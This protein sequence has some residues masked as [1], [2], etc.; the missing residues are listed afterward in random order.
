[1]E[2]QFAVAKI[3]K[4]ATSESGD[5]L[6]MI[7]R[8]SGGLS[9]VL[10]DGQRSGLS[11]K[12]ISNIV[13]RKAIQLLSEGVRDGAAARAA[14]D[15]LYAQRGGKVSATLNILSIDLVSK[16]FVISRNNAAPVLVYTQADG[17]MLL[18]Q[19]SKSVGVNR[20]TKPVIAELPLLVGTII[21]VFTDGLRHAGDW[22]GQG[23]YDPEATFR[24]MI[25]AG[26]TS[27]R[28]IADSLMAGALAKDNGRPK[29]DI[30]VLVTAVL[31]PVHST[32][33]RRMDVHLP[34]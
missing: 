16:T 21:V 24:E 12:L 25:A 3:G 26:I 29:D 9:F 11:A 31:P 17:H 5:T 13:A 23:G 32:K 2:V 15:Y 18:D 19:P 1:M 28:T 33:I 10:A 8:P 22:S 6:E 7:E 4:Y 14:H 34:L 30:S 20:N 27:P